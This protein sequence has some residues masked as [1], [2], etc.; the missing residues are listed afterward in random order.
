MERGRRE[1]LSTGSAYRIPGGAWPWGAKT[2]G[3]DLADQRGTAGGLRLEHEQVRRLTGVLQSKE[4]GQ[5]FGLAGLPGKCP[6]VQARV[7]SG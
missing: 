4:F 1:A 3:H 5:V 2:A 7:S 6:S